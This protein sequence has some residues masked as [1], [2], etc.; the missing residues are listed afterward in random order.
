MHA[1]AQGKALIKGVHRL[2]YAN[3]RG[4][5]VVA[6]ARVAAKGVD[7]DDSVAGLDAAAAL[8]VEL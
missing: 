7:A 6:L 5:P 8:G 2:T 3:C 1:R 4:I